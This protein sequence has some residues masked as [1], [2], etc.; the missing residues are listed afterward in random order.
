MQLLQVVVALNMHSAAVVQDNQGTACDYGVSSSDSQD[1]GN[2]H[3][4]AGKGVQH[5]DVYNAACWDG[6][7]PVAGT[8]DQT[9]QSWEWELSSSWIFSL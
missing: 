9:N 5:V 7:I 3:E 2:I 4:D 1:G 8:G 6:D